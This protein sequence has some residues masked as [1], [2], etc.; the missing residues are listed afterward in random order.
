MKAIYP[1]LSHTSKENKNKKDVRAFNIY[2]YVDI[3]ICELVC[4]PNYY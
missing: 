4:D 2:L 1:D 3:R